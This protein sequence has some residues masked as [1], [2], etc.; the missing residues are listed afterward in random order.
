MQAT[1]RLVS[2][3]TD[4]RISVS[5][6]ATY[7][8]GW[9]LAG[10]IDQHSSRTRDSRRDIVKKLLW[11][12][13]RREFIT[14]GTQELRAFL[15]YCSQ[16][17]NDSG[18]RWGNPRMIR[19]VRPR[20]V[21]TYHGHLRTLFR[22]LVSEGVVATSPME[23][24]PVPTARADQIQPFTAEQVSALMKAAKR[25]NAH[26]ARRDESIL[27]VLLDTGIRASELCS[28]TRADLDFQN[29]R[30]TVLGKGNK[31][32]T[33]PFGKTTA[34]ALWN[35]LRDRPDEPSA[36]LFGSERGEPLTRSGLLQLFERLGAAA[37]IRVTRCS[38]HTARHTMAIE[39]LRA[40]GNVFALQ[41]LLG[42]TGIQ[43]TQRYVA[44]AQADVEAAH[45]QFSPA[46]R[47]RRSQ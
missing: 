29:R 23:R 17:H 1:D 41:Q 39:Y 6:L 18:G 9:L 10:E 8:D 25:G 4:A 16:G 42:H 26:H 12:F 5:L 44:L 36:P 43:M 19:P 2:Q 28:I 35:Y 15:A 22:W 46:D 47:L 30:L 13:H 24:I 11:F 21:H 31:R 20:T 33:V 27:W 37:K 14:C 40:G 3:N 7:A 38:P 32:R 45:R 34:S